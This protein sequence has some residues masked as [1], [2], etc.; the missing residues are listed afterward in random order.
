MF[1]KNKG[2]DEGTIVNLCIIGLGISIII[3]Y[4]YYKN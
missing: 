4:I 1:K 2:L 3:L